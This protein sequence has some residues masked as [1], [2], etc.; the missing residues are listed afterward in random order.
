[1]KETSIEF[2]RKINERKRC[3]TNQEFDREKFGRKELGKCIEKKGWTF[4]PH[5]L[6]IIIKKVMQM[7]VRSSA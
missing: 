2:E 7:N 6:F 1:L 4:I 5:F 3:K